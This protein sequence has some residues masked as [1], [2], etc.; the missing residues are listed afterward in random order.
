MT[1]LLWFLL[2]LVSGLAAAGVAIAYIS[3]SRKKTKK[4]KRVKRARRV[5]V[6][7]ATAAPAGIVPPRYYPEPERIP[8]PPPGDTGGGHEVDLELSEKAFKYKGPKGLVF[9]LLPILLALVGLLVYA[10]VFKK[11]EK[12]K[13][14][15]PVVNI[16]I[17][18]NELH[19]KLDAGVEEKEYKVEKMPNNEVVE[20]K[21]GTYYFIDLKDAESKEMILF[22]PG[23]Y[24]RDEFERAFRDS[25]SKVRKDI[26]DLLSAG[27]VPF[28]LYVRG[29]A[30]LDGNTLPFIDRLPP[31]EQVWI[32]YLPKVPNTRNRYINNP[33]PQV[34]TE[35]YNN[36]E[37][38][39]LRASYI[40]TKLAIVGLESTIL[41]GEV[42]Q[43]RSEAKDRSV[44][45]LLYWPQ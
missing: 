11:D 43:N 3:T 26:L 6:V 29:S 30:D 17:N 18:L 27:N 14:T 36:R 5:E 4:T 23:E 21:V 12:P 37:L 22:N 34:I 7:A 41:E 24:T 15:P 40:Q 8:V 13:E 1:P 33:T 39:N 45:I 20:G 44:T 28:K 31:G 42:T 9:W 16:I 32:T 19:Q 10:A 2:G 25:M 38:P 35:K